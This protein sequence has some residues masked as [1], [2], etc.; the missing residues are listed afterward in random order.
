[1]LKNVQR[2]E[3]R[4]SS[5]EQHHGHQ[6][7]EA[8]K[9]DLQIVEEHL[10]PS[11]TRLAGFGTAIGADIANPVAHADSHVAL[12]GGHAHIVV[13]FLIAFRTNCLHAKKI[14]K[15]IAKI[16]VQV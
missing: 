16:Q 5:K 8:V 6:E 13:E 3:H 10:P 7:P 2:E 9:T 11:A 14:V 4:K 12:Q 15:K 1:M